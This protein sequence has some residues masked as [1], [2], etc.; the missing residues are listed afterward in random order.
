MKLKPCP[1]CGNDCITESEVLIKSYPSGGVTEKM[2]YCFICGGRATSK[3]WNK[4]SEVDALL[5]VSPWIPVSTRLPE[6]WRLCYFVMHEGG[7]VNKA[8]GDHQNQG[9]WIWLVD[10]AK[11]VD[12]THWMPIPK[13]EGDKE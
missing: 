12:V 9:E 11:E 13:I 2:A 6:D 8:Y 3:Q 1:F 5:S 7:I 4:R 10:G